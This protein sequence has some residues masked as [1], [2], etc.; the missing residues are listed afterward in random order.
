MFRVE[1]LGFRE[2]QFQGSF[3]GA[4]FEATHDVVGSGLGFGSTI[5]CIPA[6]AG[7]LRTTDP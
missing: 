7:S 4:F 6:L 3:I 1:G 2:F 5:Q